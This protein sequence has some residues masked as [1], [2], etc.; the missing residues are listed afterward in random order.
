VHDPSELHHA[1]VPGG[2]EFDDFFG[3]A[4]AASV[5]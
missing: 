1:E 4:L 5:P 2:V 3:E